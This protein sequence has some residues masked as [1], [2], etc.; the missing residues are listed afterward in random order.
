MSIHPEHNF[1]AFIAS[2]KS[3]L[4]NLPGELAHR[5]M[6][7]FRKPTQDAILAHPNYR[8]S[9][10]LLTLYEVKTE[11]HF[12]LIER[13]KYNGSHSGQISL[14]GGKYEKE[15]KSIKHTALRETEEEIGIH[16]REVSIIGQLSDVFI[17]VS[18]FLIHPF[19]GAVHQVPNLTLN[20]REVKEVVISNVSE[21]LDEKNRVT[22]RIKLDNGMILNKVPAFN[23]QG[24][25]VWGAT[26]LML[27]EFKL[28]IQKI[29]QKKSLP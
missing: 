26:A 5:E 18:E 25:I 21:L 12:I 20:T 14:P 8:T 19:I 11:L 28:L 15:D 27:N 10:V 17:P 24:K 3:E 6:A 16:R 9:A 7:P 2:L 23:L 4:N 22:T 13:Q 29:K 1:P